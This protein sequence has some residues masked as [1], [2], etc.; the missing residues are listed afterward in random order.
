MADAPDLRPGSFG[1]VGSTPISG[2]RNENAP[3]SGALV[4]EFGKFKAEG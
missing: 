3:V 2:T 1:S 4:F